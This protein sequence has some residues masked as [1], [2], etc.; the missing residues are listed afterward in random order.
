MQP[1]RK[2][3]SSDMEYFNAST[4]AYMCYE[5]DGVTRPRSS[6]PSA[7]A[8]VTW[9]LLPE[10]VYVQASFAPPFLALHVEED[11]C[12][13]EATRAAGRRAGLRCPECNRLLFRCPEYKVRVRELLQRCDFSGPEGLIDAYQGQR[14]VCN[15]HNSDGVAYSFQEFTDFHYGNVARADV[16]WQDSVPAYELVE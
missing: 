10:P 2:D 4:V 12:C 16:H 7:G 15:G 3:V 8:E 14:R 1:A 13:T 11:A 5:S 6:L 9:R